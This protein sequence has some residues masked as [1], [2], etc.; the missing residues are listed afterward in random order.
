MIKLLL[1]YI[2]FRGWEAEKSSKF[3]AESSKDK[4]NSNWDF[5]SG[6]FLLVGEL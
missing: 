1:N 3:K 2:I 6:V 4:G 5:G